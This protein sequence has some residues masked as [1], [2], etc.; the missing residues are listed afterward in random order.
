MPPRNCPGAGWIMV[1]TGDAVVAVN[2]VSD[3]AANQWF[4]DTRAQ[5]RSMEAGQ[6][7]HVSR[8]VVEDVKQ[9]LKHWGAWKFGA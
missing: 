7:Q 4:V 2:F 5:A 9:K 8:R 3:F 6:A 1:L